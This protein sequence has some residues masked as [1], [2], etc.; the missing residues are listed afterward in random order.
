MTFLWN[1]VNFGYCFS[2]SLLKNHTMPHIAT[3]IKVY[4]NSSTIFHAIYG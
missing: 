1:S 3:C 4:C 2:N